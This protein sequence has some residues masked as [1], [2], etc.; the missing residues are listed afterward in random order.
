MVLKKALL[1]DFDGTIA[2]SPRWSG[3]VHNA[4]IFHGFDPG[5][6]VVRDHMR[7]GFTWHTPENAYTDATG[8]KWWIN[9]FA[10]FNIL[11]ERLGVTEFAD[12]LNVK[13]RK[14]ILNPANYQLYDDTVST[15]RRCVELDYANIIV[16]NNFPEL[17][18]VIRGLGLDGYFNGYAVSAKIGYEKPRK[19]I[20]EYALELAGKPTTCYMIG[21]NPAADIAG[22][23][24]AGLSTVLVRR[25]NSGNEGADWAKCGADY[26][27]RDLSEIPRMIAPYGRG[28]GTEI[29]NKK[30]TGCL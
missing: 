9:M 14:F 21:D 23:K 8:E 3:S 17:E 24:A 20:F 26:V 5:F 18:D 13:A 30:I 2:R 25:E 22:G 27:C 19:E 7:T 4:L 12:Q 15:L 10:H 28:R 6:S 1:W 11:Y 16:S 29:K